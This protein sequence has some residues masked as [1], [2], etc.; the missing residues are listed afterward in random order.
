MMLNVLL[1]NYLVRR[2]STAKFPFSLLES[3]SLRPREQ[4]LLP[5]V[6]RELVEGKVE[7]VVI[8]DVVV[9]TVVG[10]DVVG[11]QV[12]V[13]VAYASTHLHLCLQLT[14]TFSKRQN[15]ADGPTNAPEN[16][17]PLN[18]I[19][20]ENSTVEP[21]REASADA[22]NEETADR[23][24]AEGEHNKDNHGKSR[25]PRVQKQRG[26]PEDGIPS[27]TKVMVANLPYDLSED[28]VIPL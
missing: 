3:P 27:K 20:N 13:G 28:K 25:G 9:A 8:L 1:E 17:G 21:G 24:N 4:K 10:V 26:P 2:S 5:V 12:V 16:S 11:V 7:N 14:A 15:N 6:V 22:G 19:T 18:D 23:V